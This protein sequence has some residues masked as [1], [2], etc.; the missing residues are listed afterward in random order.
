MD[1]E[2]KI[3]NWRDQAVCIEVDPE[4]FFPVGRSRPALEQ[5]D[6]AKAVCNSCSV[7]Q[8]CLKWAMDNHEKHGVWGGLSEYERRAI[9][10]RRAAR[11]AILSQ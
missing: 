10:G 7:K 4:L 8:E 1:S 5:T 3:R 6:R 11:R 9:R 2:K